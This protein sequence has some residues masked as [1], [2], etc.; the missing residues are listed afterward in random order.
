MVPAFLF[1]KNKTLKVHAVF[2]YISVKY[3]KLVCSKNFI[4]KCLFLHNLTTNIE[5]I[6]FKTSKITYRYRTHYG[7][8]DPHCMSWQLLC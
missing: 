5:V 7:N 4:L 3:C 2:Q 8:D 1:P 6:K